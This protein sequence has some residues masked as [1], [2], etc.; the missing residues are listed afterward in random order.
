[1][2]AKLQ[3]QVSPEPNLIGPRLKYEMAKRGISSARL[4]K[5][6]G[7][8]TSF[9]Y[10]IISGKSANPSTVKLARVAESLGVSLTSLVDNGDP[11]NESSYAARLQTNEYVTIPRLTVDVSSGKPSVV[12]LH[13]DGEA[14]CFRKDW[15]RD[16]LGAAPS[17]LRLVQMRGDS[18]EPTFFNNEL[19]LVDTTRKLPA[20]PGL[21]VVFDGF[22]LNI[23]RL[24]YVT[25]SRP[26]RLRIIPDNAQYSIYE[27]SV[28][29]TVV[30][31]RIVWFSREV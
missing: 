17:D 25:G 21:F 3:R 29:E 10:D 20:P 31:G 27:R 8:K 6:A 2:Q 16:R 12:S 19:M 28:E 15:I 22:G 26:A 24:E 23:K 18:M 5:D 7:V 13:Q 9:I 4:A 30:I 14:F 1:M 11:G